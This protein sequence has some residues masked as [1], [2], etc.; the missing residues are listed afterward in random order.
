MPTQI[1][2]EE[3]ALTIKG[4]ASQLKGIASLA[5]RLVKLRAEEETA[6]IR[7]KAIQAKR[8]DLEE[9]ELPDA[10]DAVGMA[11]FKTKQGDEIVVKQIVSASIPKKNLTEALLWLR[12]NGHENLIKSNLGIAL[13]RGQTKEHDKV[14]AALKKIPNIEISDNE[15]VHAQ[16][17]GAWCREQLSHGTAIPQELLGVYVGRRAEVKPR[18]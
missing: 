4:S 7:L 8:R 13:A 12:T 3:D 17:L 16:T 1:N 18:G 11:S 9:R 5:D 15:S 10:M 14:L 2:F 6:E